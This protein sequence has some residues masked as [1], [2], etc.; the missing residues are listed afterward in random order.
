MP[1]ELNSAGL[2]R[3]LVESGLNYEQIGHAIGRNR[4]YVRQIDKGMKPGT[5]LRASLDALRTRLAHL[6]Q[7]EARQVAARNTTVPPP[8]RRRT[9]AGEQ[10]RTRK[11]MTFA[12]DSFS[13]STV[14]KDASRHG[15]ASLNRQLSGLPGDRRVGVT[16]GF[17]HRIAVNNTSGGVVNARQGDAGTYGRQRG[18][19]GRGG[20]VEMEFPNAAAV[21]Q[22]VEVQYGG[23][24]SAFLAAKAA[25]AGYVSGAADERGL[26]NHM[27]SIELRSY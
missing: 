1:G 15:A 16:I 4:S 5:G 14:K 6:D 13:T 7:P 19:T 2:I 12:G 21:R 18:E 22:E 25:E 27:T 10:A 24:L 8:P 26:V 3:E 20:Y 9:K 23:N 17:D 11:S